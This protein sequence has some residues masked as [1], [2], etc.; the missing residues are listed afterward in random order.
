MCSYCVCLQ[1]ESAVSLRL[2]VT[3]TVVLYSVLRL[4]LSHHYGWEVRV[5]TLFSKKV[6]YNVAITFLS[7]PPLRPALTHHYGCETLPAS[8]RAPPASHAERRWLATVN[9]RAEW[10]S[11]IGEQ[12]WLATV[13]RRADWPSK[14]A[15]ECGIVTVESDRYGRV[16]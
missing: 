2:R 6:S 15:R 1:R 10:P 14:S 9:R 12:S 16:V 5:V 4:S 7:M 13:N 11:R 8:T 3:V